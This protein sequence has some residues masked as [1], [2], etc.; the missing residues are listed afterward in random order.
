MTKVLGSKR[1]FSDA[2][3]DDCM[4][5]LSAVCD[6]VAIDEYQQLKNFTHHYYTTRYQHCLN[7][8]WYSYLMAKKAHLDAISCARG[9]MLHDFYL[10]DTHIDKKYSKKHMQTHPKIALQNA[11]KYFSLNPIEIDCIVHHMWPR[12]KSRPVTKEG[13]IVTIADKYAASLEF[14]SHPFYAVPKHLIDKVSNT[15]HF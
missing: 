7:V 10:Y 15:L 11:Q 2:T 1:V 8:A 4:E 6:I 5:F 12:V 14:C 9:A 3:D 13:Y